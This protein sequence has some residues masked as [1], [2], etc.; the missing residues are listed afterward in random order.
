MR[1]NVTLPSSQSTSSSGSSSSGT[2]LDRLLKREQTLI[3]QLRDLSGDTSLDEKTRKEKQK[4]LSAELQ[5]VEMRIAQLR[6]EGEKSSGKVAGSSIEG[7]TRKLAA[8]S[9]ED[10][11]ATGIDVTV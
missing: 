5:M 9:R 8:N 11:T 2:E 1:I 10:S 7:L 4:L 3:Q 6:Q